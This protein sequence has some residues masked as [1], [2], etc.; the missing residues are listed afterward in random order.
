MTLQLA[1]EDYRQNPKARESLPF[2]GGERWVRGRCRSPSPEL[3]RLREGGVGEGVEQ[4]R[5]TSLLL[6]I[7]YSKGGQSG[8]WEVNPLQHLPCWGGMKGVIPA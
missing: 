4:S 1:G 8:S 3:S 5:I 7:E 6:S 2:L